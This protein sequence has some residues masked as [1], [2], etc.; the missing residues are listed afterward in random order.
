MIIVPLQRECFKSILQYS[1]LCLRLYY[2]RLVFSSLCVCVCVVVVVVVV[3][4]LKNCFCKFFMIPEA[5]LSY[6]K[7]PMLLSKIQDVVMHKTLILFVL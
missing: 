5:L 6:L 7:N 3:P 4:L 2:F 1:S